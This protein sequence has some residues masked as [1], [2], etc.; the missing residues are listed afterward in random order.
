MKKALLIALSMTFAT[1]SY[2]YQGRVFLDKNQ[3]GTYDRGERLMSD[4]MVTDG[5]NVV[6]TNSK[7]EFDLPGHDRARFISVTTPSGYKPGNKHYIKI[8]A[9]TTSYDFALEKW[10]RVGRDGSHS[11]IQIADTE[12]R[13]A[14]PTH[15]IWVNNVRDYAQ[16][17]GAGFIMHTGDICYEGGMA[18][19]IELMNSKNMGI[20]MYYGIGNHDLIKGAYGEEFFESLYG[21]VWYSFDYGNVHYVMTPM[22]GGDYPPS[23]SEADVYA[24]LKNDL[25]LIKKDQPIVI[26]NHDVLTSS[27]E[28]IIKKNDNERLLLNRDYN[29][30]A[31]IYGHWHNHFIKMLGGVKTISTSALNKGGIDHSTSAF[32]TYNV[33]SKGDLDTQLRYTFI[34]R[35][36]QIASIGSGIAAMDLAGRIT[37]NV[38]TYLSQALTKNVSYRVFDADRNILAKTN[39]K[40]NSDWTWLGSFTL[41]ESMINR[42]VFVEATAQFENGE[43]AKVIESFVYQPTKTKIN[44]GADWTNLVGNS[45][46]IATSKEVMKTPLAIS[47]VNNIGAN[48]Y[49][50]SP[51]V[52]NGVV[53]VAALDE[54]LR[55]E[56][57]VYALNAITGEQLWKFTTRNSVKNTIVIE[58]G[59]VFAQDGEGY[60]YA[61]NAESGNLDWEAKLNAPVFPVVIEGL[62]ANNGIVYAGIGKSLSA[63]DAKTGRP[64]WNNKSWG[65]NQATTSTIT[66]NEDYLIMSSQWSAIY[67]H[68]AK[69]GE[70]LWNL[71]KDGIRHRASSPALYGN[72]AYFISRNSLFVLDAQTGNILSKKLFDY[73]VD[74]TSTPLVTEKLIIFGTITNGLVA[75]D[76]ENFE[77][78]WSINTAPSLVYTGPYETSPSNSV[79]TS[80]I[81]VGNHVFFGASDGVLY[82]VNLDS[83][84]LEWSHEVG[85]PV[86]SSMATSGNA[87]FVSDYSGNVYGFT[88]NK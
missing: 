15:Q 85:A 52:S 61:I 69:T 65:V 58:S 8:D 2:A 78:K 12:I 80:P 72:L 40:Q 31:W 25:S 11:F 36:I 54:D 88:S 49:F 62:A 3:N 77:E 34:D 74:A 18:A 68:D 76:R 37:V 19:H 9:A 30:K 27:E 43:V 28:F 75:I 41:P 56:G 13:D 39:L 55:G 82:G 57:G 70:L 84:K 64:I 32:R 22:P 7:G 87:I 1:H 86:F 16:N 14:D 35:D 81:R 47:W 5:L 60:L 4:V 20:P 59:K 38:N 53:Y 29:L 79:E 42:E 46:H 73:S 23:Y 83:G 50:T 26:F 63:Y 21:P 66:V 44:L 6:K 51:V 24:W 48:I 33:S 10:D 67:G 45:S 17:Q 71:S